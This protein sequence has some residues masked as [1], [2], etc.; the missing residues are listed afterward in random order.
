M[1]VQRRVAGSWSG[2][3]K[4]AAGHGYI[5]DGEAAPP[6]TR[7]RPLHA[8]AAHVHVHVRD[9]PLGGIDQLQRRHK[10]DEATIATLTAMTIAIVD[11][12]DH[13]IVET[14]LPGEAM[15]SSTLSVT[16]R[17]RVASTLVTDS[18]GCGSFRW[19]P[20]ANVREY[21]PKRSTTPAWRAPMM[22]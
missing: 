13:L 19:K 18:I 2:E 6:E 22:V 12:G 16:E 11:T 8:E 15:N 9:R 3:R 21:S 1:Q 10:A 14:T 7:R 20:G 4:E 5:R 17:I